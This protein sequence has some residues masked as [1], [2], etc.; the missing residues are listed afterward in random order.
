[1]TIKIYADGAVLDEMLA[2]YR[3]GS[4][5]GFTTNPT[6]M[7]R[8][9]VTDYVDFAREVTA[10]IPD[11]PVS[12]EVFGDDA[13]QMRREAHRLAEFGKNV[14]VKIPILNTRGESSIPLIREL[15]AEGISLNI[16]AI[17]LEEQVSETVEALTAGVPSI[18]S[19]F[20]GRIAD[21]GRDPM[22]L[23]RRSAELCHAKEGVELLWASTREALN[24]AQAEEA[25]ADII[26]VTPSIIAKAA[27]SGM[28]LAE[29]SL[30]TVRGFAAD[31]R[32]LG[33][34]IV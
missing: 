26:T 34:S 15:S 31:S 12:F 28:D 8:A 6:L 9:G 23:M 21:T 14:Y 24:I 25:G 18:V 27:L 4:V 7:K 2:A 1:M 30:E 19:V 33:F 13:E 20:A 17:M 22:P 29:L 32:E 3:D 11:L 10:A 5:A 16:T